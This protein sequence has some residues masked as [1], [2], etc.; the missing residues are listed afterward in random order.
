MTQDQLRVALHD[1]VVEG[2]KALL[3][4]ILVWG[5]LS[6]RIVEV[7]AY[8]GEDDPACHAYRKT[9][10][11]NMALFGAPGHAYVYF[12]YG[13]HWMLNVAAHEIGRGAGVLIRAA[14]PL[15]GVERMRANR[16]GVADRELL[17]GPGKLCKAYGI[18]SLQNAVDLLGNQDGLHIVAREGATPRILMGARVGIAVGKWHDV[19]WRFMDADRLEWVSRRP[20]SKTT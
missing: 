18:D 20:Q 17:S 8:R 13:V 15:T 6:A 11:K 2:A 7:E 14:E 4:A 3:G 19:P 5:D 1:D 9:V 10:M 16:G 12:N